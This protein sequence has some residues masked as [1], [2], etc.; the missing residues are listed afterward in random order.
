[1]RRSAADPASSVVACA[2]SAV[3]ASIEG[4]HRRLEASSGHRA[5]SSA[6]V[7]ACSAASSAGVRGD[8]LRGDD[9]VDGAA[10]A[11]AIRLGMP[12][13]ILSPRMILQ[14]VRSAAKREAADSADADASASAADARTVVADMRA[15][16]ATSRHA[17]K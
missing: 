2:C 4:H 11:A 14:S 10:A 17:S 3:D 8:G 9:N 6:C 16:V 15:A 5:E 13:S 12:S 7:T 1:M